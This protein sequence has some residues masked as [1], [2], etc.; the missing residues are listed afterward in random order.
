MRMRPKKNRESRLEK[1][2]YLF[3][4]TDE[5]GKLDISS[6]FS[7]N[8][9]EKLYI[10]IGCGKGA[11]VTELSKRNPG[12]NIVAI[13]RVSDVLMMAME[14]ADREGCVNIA[15]LNENAD[16]I[17]IILPE[18]SVDKLYLNFSDPWPR[19]K[20]AKRR[21]TSPMFLERYKRILKDGA[22]I[23]FKT[24]N[25]DLFEYTLE[26]LNAAGFICENIT[27]DLH[28]SLMNETNIETEYERSFS[29][30]GYK[31]NYLEAFLNC[32]I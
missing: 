28:A 25:T 16:K 8:Q 11:F 14:K 6:T 5:E 31:I 29:A 21:L 9:K 10:E 32:H 24:D 30:L 13:E 18:K 23:Y 20:N 17:D 7:E 22:R 3:A 1:V 2:S 15:F 27:N 4:K 19:K 12:V 26:T